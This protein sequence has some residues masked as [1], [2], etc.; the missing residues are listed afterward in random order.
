MKYNC[1]LFDMD[2]T[3]V[4]TYQG[5]Y[6]SYKYAFEKLQLSFP[7]EKLVGKVIGAPLFSVFKDVLNFSEEKASKATEYYRQ[8][9]SENG[10]K[11]V[12]V[13]EGMEDTLKELKKS[14]CIL[15]VATL[16]REDFA[17]EILND[18]NL[19]KY[20]DIVCG[21][22]KNDKLTKAQLIERCICLNQG[23]KEQTILV[24][25]SE[26]DAEGAKE[27]RVD[28]CAVLYGFGFNEA[29]SLKNKQISM[30]A[31][32]PSEIFSIISNE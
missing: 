9:Y 10:R 3:L 5:I 21:I 16:K 23:T 15:G 8:Y 7:G 30:I 18:L 17:I 22:D 29:K 27:A 20:F 6:N 1:V 11:E 13:Y 19:S 2:G 25:D 4:N 14:G 12:S 32:N 26:Y 31:E 28:F 24:G